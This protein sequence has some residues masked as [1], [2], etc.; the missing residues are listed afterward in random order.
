MSQHWSASRSCLPSLALTMPDTRGNH[1]IQRCHDRGLGHVAVEVYEA[2]RLALQAM[3]EGR[4]KDGD[5]IQHVF[6]LPG[7]EPRAIYRFRAG[8]GIFYAVVANQCAPITLIT[9]DMLTYYRAHRAVR[10]KARDRRRLCK[11]RRAE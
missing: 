7:D 8:G 1:F 10:S 5:F 3:R 4:H 2:L 6:D 9:A 11:P